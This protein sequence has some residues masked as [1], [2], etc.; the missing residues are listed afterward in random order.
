[1]TLNTSASGGLFGEQVTI[2]AM[3]RY[4]PDSRAESLL[5]CMLSVFELQE[6]NL[7]LNRRLRRSSTSE[8]RFDHFGA[9][10]SPLAT[11]SSAASPYHRELMNHE[12]TTYAWL[13]AVSHSHLNALITPFRSREPPK[14]HC[15]TL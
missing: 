4:Y 9:N 5:T 8:Y 3:A 14:A 10:R 7:K 12:A 6:S 15:V 13:M 1:M 2:N 11:D